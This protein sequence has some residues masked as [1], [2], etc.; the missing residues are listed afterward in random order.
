MAKTEYYRDFREHL[1]ALEERG[2]LLRIQREINKDTE[3]MPLVRW[4]FR[5]LEERERKAF[6]VRERRRFQRPTL[7]DAGDRRHLGRDHR[8]LRHRHDV[9]A[10]PNP[11][12]LDA[13][14]AQSH[15]A[16]NG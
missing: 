8:D 1:K 14:A 5:G 3:L 10:G 6:H 2:K 9:R 4:Q 12:A 15:R 13:G 11:R 7:H 16:G